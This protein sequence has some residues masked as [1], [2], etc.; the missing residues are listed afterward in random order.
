M[1]AYSPDQI[2]LAI[3][4]EGQ[5]ARTD[6]ADYLHH[7]VISPRGIVI[8][9]ATGI[10]ESSLT[11]YANNGD[12]DSLT[13]PHDAISYDADSVGVFQQRAEWWG[14]AAER[15]SPALSA[16]MFYHH[17]AALPDY[18][19]P[20]NSPGSQAQAVQG[21]A[22]PDRYDEHIDEAQAIYNRL[23]K[24][25]PTG[26]PEAVL[27]ASKNIV[28]APAFTEV[29]SF[30]SNCEPRYGHAV[31]L[32]LLHTQEGDDDA[33]GLAGFLRSTEGTPNPRSY[34]YTISQDA[35]GHVTLCDVTDTDQACW[36]VA[37]S[38]YRSINLC[39]AGS[40]S[41]WDSDTWMQ[42][43][44]EAIRVAAYVA[45]LDCRKYGI[46]INVLSPPYSQDPPGIADHR[47]CSQY[48]Q[49]GNNHGDVGDGFPW[50]EFSKWVAYYSN[51]A[52][53]TN[54]LGDDMATVPQ[55]QWDEVYQELTKKYPSRSPLR[56]LG[57]GL[58]DT[59]AGMVLNTDGNL[60]VL[61]VKNLAELGDGA[62]LELLA[63][64]AGAD[65]N[66]YP[67]RANDAALARAILADIE[68]TR[69]SVIKNYLATTTTKKG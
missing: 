61:L 53:N 62:A 6:G 40:F 7:P 60:H 23:A 2:A 39:F 25:A 8:A 24:N 58:V 35:Q 67:D 5:S 33:Q 57:E 18:N 48:L 29:T 43:H 32:F 31:D 41:S 64:V 11:M 1:P 30:T 34:H 46:G 69:P 20:A 27:V 55:S 12:P 45:V 56:H 38:N 51:T 36:A 66:A 21:S 4:A 49:D 59:E 50:G 19:D 63:E 54:N 42:N 28:T 52:I 14:T 68:V 26:L 9:L 44:G 3:I 10:V 16:A 22:F 37:A 65:L 17:L 15:M 47:Y 13:F